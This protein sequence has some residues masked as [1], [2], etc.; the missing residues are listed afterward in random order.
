[1]YH[2]HVVRGLPIRDDVGKIAKWN[3]AAIDIN[4]RKRAEEALK[5]HEAR[6]RA[7]V[8]NAVDGIIVIDEHGLIDAFNPAAEHMFGFRAEEVIGQNVSLLMSSPDREEHDNHM[9]RYRR[10]GEKKIIGIGREVLGQRKD[11]STVPH[12]LAVSEL[13]VGG[14]RM[15]T[16]ILRDITGRKQAEE[17]LANRAA[18]LA[19]S[20]AELEV[21]A[22]I[23]SHDLQEPLRMV[24]SFTQRLAQRYQGQLDEKADQYIELAVDGCK[25]MQRLI[26]D[27]LKYSRVTTKGGPPVPVDSGAVLARTLGDLGAAIAEAGAKITHDSMPIVAADA[28]QLGQLFQN[29]IGNALKFHSAEPPHVHISARRDHKWWTF[30]VTDNGIGID[31]QYYDRIFT[32]FQ[33]LHTAEEYPGTG[34]GLAVCQKIVERQGGRIWVES[35]PGRGS[36]F[37]FTLPT[38][39][40]GESLVTAEKTT[41]GGIPRSILQHEGLVLG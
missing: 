27:L 1:V 28:T 41:T 25:R 33:R 34:I 3:W 40:D 20:N 14:R 30:A 31:P 18:E 8:D 2:W 15:F 23:A 13:T 5:D 26:E 7:I 21:F 10:T 16:G 32:V 24:S 39:P 37:S 36:T 35:K 9:A 29:L 6:L 12:E 19:R 22:Y 4:E 38:V 17:S 11:G